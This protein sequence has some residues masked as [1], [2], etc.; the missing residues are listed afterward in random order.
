MEANTNKFNYKSFKA[1]SFEELDAAVEQWLHEVGK[2]MLSISCWF[3]GQRHYAMLCTNPTE[4]V[5]CSG[6][7]GQSQVSREGKLLVHPE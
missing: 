2:R 3:D 6:G 4:V 5:I 7:Y 1:N